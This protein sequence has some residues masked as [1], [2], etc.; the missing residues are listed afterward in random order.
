MN[1]RK[2]T[3]TVI[4]GPVQSAKSTE[5][6]SILIRKQGA[7]Y[8]IVLVEHCDDLRYVEGSVV[9]ENLLRKSSTTHLG[10]RCG[11][12]ESVVSKNLKDIP[13][14]VLS[15]ADYVGI[16]EGQFFGEALV[17][18]VKDQLIKGRHVL[19]SGLLSDF[20][21][22]PFKNMQVLDVLATYRIPK[23]G[24]CNAEHPSSKRN[25]CGKDA[26]YSYK[27]GGNPDLSV[28]IGGPDMYRPVCGDCYDKL[29]SGEIKIVI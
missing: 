2:G 4:T 9:D 25:V 11:I 20:H 21:L 18:F 12:Q 16:D 14:Q 10:D 29:Q 26:P 7:G 27:I 22:N 28:E 23:L 15:E 17:P 13:E 3:L 24:T 6:R 5:L 1:K 8:H 19:V